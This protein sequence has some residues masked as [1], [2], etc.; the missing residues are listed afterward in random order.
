MKASDVLKDQVKW[1]KQRCKDIN[2]EIEQH[3]KQFSGWYGDFG[4]D[5]L[6]AKLAECVA[7]KI[8]TEKYMKK[9]RHQGE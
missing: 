3:S 5:A 2:K 1:L 6:K 4:G 9:L 7:I 8:S